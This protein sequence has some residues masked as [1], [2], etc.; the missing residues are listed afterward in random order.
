[1]MGAG[2]LWQGEPLDAQE[3]SPSRDGMLAARCLVQDQIS[4][5]KNF[6]ILAF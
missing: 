2:I 6:H 1:M 5:D 3:V 4:F